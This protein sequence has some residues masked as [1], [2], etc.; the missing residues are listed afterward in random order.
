MEKEISQGVLNSFVANGDDSR[1]GRMWGACIDQRQ[2]R[3][4]VYI[5]RNP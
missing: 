1:H 4:A 2:E 5:N 3:I